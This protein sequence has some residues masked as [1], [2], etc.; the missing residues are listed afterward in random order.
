MTTPVLFVAYP[1]KFNCPSK[2]GR[3]L[4]SLTINLERFEITYI[5]DEQ[6]LISGYT[7]NNKKV[8]N[9][10]K[11]DDINEISTIDYAIVFS[12]HDLS[13]PILASLKSQ[14]TKLRVVDTPITNVVNID[15]DDEYDDYIG[16][17]SLWGNPFQLGI[18]G[19]REKVIGT[20]A[21]HL[22]R[23]FLKFTYDDLVKLKGKTLGCH[24][25]PAECHGDVLAK[26]LNE[27][28]DGL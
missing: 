1:R 25:K 10:I 15:K 23:G 28:D 8:S 4:D 12:D 21:Y 19:D 2:F 6:G 17:G 16:R 22:S 27:F 9:T 7:T 26:Y 11:V 18:D 14:G 24:C 5:S 20:Y 3:K 13:E